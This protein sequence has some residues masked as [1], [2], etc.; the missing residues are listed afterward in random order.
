MKNRN[1]FRGCM[2]GGAA[3]DALGYAVEFDRYKEIVKQY[4]ESG[5]TEYALDPADHTCHISDDTQMALFTAGGLLTGRA[6]NAV[7]GY[8]V[9][10]YRAYLDWYR[11][12]FGEGVEADETVF[13]STWLYRVPALNNQRAPGNT[14]MA[15]LSSGK[16]GSIADPIN[17]SKG[18]GGVMRVAP[19]GLFFTPGE[20]LSAEEIDRLGAE[21]AAITHG[22]PLGWLPSALLT[23]II[24]TI[25][26]S[27]D[28][29][30]PSKT[31]TVPSSEECRRI[32]QEV[33]E[34]SLDAILAEFPEY[35]EAQELAGLIRK[36]M[37]LA[38]QDGKDEPLIRSLGEGWVGDEALAI[39]VFCAL[40]YADNFEKCLTASVN[41]N[42]DSDSTGAV[43]GNILG[44]FL[45]ADAIPEKFKTSLELAAVITDVADDLYIQYQPIGDDLWTAKY[46]MNNYK[47]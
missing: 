4:G 32:L 1:T 17:N 16:M 30:I 33:F 44:A 23:R 41:H 6:M 38:V 31:G 36:A 20:D 26:Y 39:S 21:S 10:I 12:Q 42:G 28:L 27:E 40:R 47:I 22:H 5:I 14:C 18:C 25:T 19:V 9:H 45:G 13:G 37:E 2:I 29:P 43:A 15:A 46:I 11:A 24:S 7:L 8:P 35:E 3:G 34:S